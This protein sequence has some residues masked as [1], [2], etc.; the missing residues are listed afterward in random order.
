MASSVSAGG[1]RVMEALDELPTELLT[2]VVL[3]T[4]YGH[5]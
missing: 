3:N 2:D 1:G 4:K 5:W